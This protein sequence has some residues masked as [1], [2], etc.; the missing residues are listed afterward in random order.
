MSDSK[1]AEQLNVDKE[2]VQRWD[3]LNKKR[4]FKRTSQTYFEVLKKR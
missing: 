1:I 2:T 4:N 3:K